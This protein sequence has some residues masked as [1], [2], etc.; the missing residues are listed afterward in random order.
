MLMRL[1]VVVVIVA[2]L[3]GCATIMEGSSQSV[4]VSTTPAGALCNVDRAGTHIGTVAAT[5]GSIHLDKSKNDLMI[6]C[7]KE[8]FQPATLAQSPKFVGTTFGNI[9]A[10]G[11]IGVAVDAASGANYEYPSDI[12][13]DLAP[14]A[15][16]STS[17]ES[18]GAAGALMMQPAVAV[19]PAPGVSKP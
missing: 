17:P 11:L 13:L 6:S 15:I 8:G 1:A 12:H 18:G 4:S 19:A 3:P 2:V 7:T 10:G 14:V 5:P 9:V 16:S